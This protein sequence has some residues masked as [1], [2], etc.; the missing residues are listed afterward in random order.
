MSTFKDIVLQDLR[1]FINPDE[2][3][4]LH[5]VNGKEIPV[6]VDEDLLKQQ[7]ESINRGDGIYYSNLVVF[8]QEQKM[9]KVPVIGELFNLDDIHYLVEDVGESMGLVEIKLGANMI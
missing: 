4:D 8:I 6:M 9:D 7:A 3:G 1:T 5:M 2:F